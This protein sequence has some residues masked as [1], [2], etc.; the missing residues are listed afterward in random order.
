MSFTNF[1]KKGTLIVLFF[2]FFLNIHAKSFN[3]KA[4]IKDIYYIQ[5]KAKK[6]CAISGEDLDNTYKTNYI[7]KLSDGNHKQYAALRFLAEDWDAIKDRVVQILV[8][9]ASTQKF[10]DARGAFFVINSSAETKYSKYSKV[11]FA[12]K[13]DA[14]KFQKKY[15]GDIR[16]FD[17]TLYLGTRDIELD[18]KYFK[19][20]KEKSYKKGQRIFES[21]CQKIDPNDYP[22]LIDLKLDIRDKKLCGKI[23]DK[24]LQILSLYL[25]DVK[26]FGALLENKE[27]MKVPEGSKCPVCGMFVYK[28]PKWAAKIVTKTHTHYFDGVKDMMKFYFDP[29]GYGH[30][31]KIKD[32]L[33]I[34]VSDYYTLHQIDAKTAWYVIGSN[35][36]GPMGHELIPFKKKEDAKTFMK[37]HFGKELISFD[38]ITND[39]VWELDK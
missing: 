24:N 17:F 26:R 3:Q 8:V 21:V 23:R 14:L 22:S 34:Q 6:W 18:Q 36:Y 27:R 20:K 4:T 5:T 30:D 12:Q 10:I 16:D 37:N 35:V 15:G 9:D 2:S 29:K 31:N 28:Y 11:A 1:I 33:D 13:K 32:F 7:A 25:W 39:K 19:A 38:N